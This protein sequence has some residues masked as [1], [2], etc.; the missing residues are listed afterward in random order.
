[1]SGQHTPGPW[2]FVERID[3]YT[4]IEGDG[5]FQILDRENEQQANVLCT[6]QPWPEKQA[7]MIANARLI[8]AAP[9]LL[10]AAKRALNVLLAMGET[11]NPKNALGALDAAIKKATGAA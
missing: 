2:F 7:E 1:M 11:P 5:C 6:R 10:A 3:G 8:A 9:E 4:Q